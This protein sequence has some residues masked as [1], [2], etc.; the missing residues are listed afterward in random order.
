MSLELCILA[1]G[2]MGNA[3]VLRCPSGAMLIDFG[4]GPRTLERRLVGTGVG[5]ADLSAVCL[6]HLDSDHFNRNWLPTLVRQ[7]VAIHC[8]AHAAPD[9]VGEDP[10]V[11]PLVR[12]FDA[13]AFEPLPGVTFEPIALAHDREGSHG[14]VIDGFGYRIGYATDLGRV[15]GELIDR[16]RGCDLVAIESNYDRAMQEASARP[17]F[18]K[19]RITGGSGHLSNGQAL[20]AIRAILDRAAAVAD[21]LPEHIVLLHRSQECNCPRLLRRTFGRDPRI[22]VRLTLAE[23]HRRTEWLRR[24]TVAPAIGEQLTLG[25]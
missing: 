16:F 12:A 23:Q 1:S 14:F 21:R 2:S 5:V 25:F 9:V 10:V 19:R 22:A 4:I 7:G 20:A 3:A 24:M 6:T 18:L 13:D 17:A 15:P 8:H 11:R